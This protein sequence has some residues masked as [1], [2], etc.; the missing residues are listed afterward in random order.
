MKYKKKYKT[1]FILS[2]NGLWENLILDLN[3]SYYFK[4]K[5]IISG[6]KFK[7]KKLFWINSLDALIG[8]FLN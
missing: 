5:V 4:P 3:K 8:K 2:A 6:K 7:N 1:V